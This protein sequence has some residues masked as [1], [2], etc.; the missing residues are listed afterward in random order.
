MTHQRMYA[1]PEKA[2]VQTTAPPAR[3]Q[4]MEAIKVQRQATARLSTRTDPAEREA[5]ATARKI[6][7]MQLPRPP[8]RKPSASE[9]PAKGAF[10][11]AKQSSTDRFAESIAVLRKEIA[12]PVIARRENEGE[13]VP[14][15]VAGRMAA[16]SGGGSPLPE[17]VRQFM[18]P[19]FGANFDGVR[20][21][22]DDRAARLSEQIQA[23]AFTRGNEIFFGANRFQPDTAGGRELIAHELTHTIQQGAATQDKNT[24][25]RSEDVSV[26]QRV[27]GRNQRLGLDTVLNFFADAANAIPGY[28]MFTIVIGM[29]P[30]NGSAVD[31]SAANIL[32]AIVEF[33]PGGNAITRALDAYSVFEK[34]G[35]W[36]EG[37]LQS[38]GISGQSIKDALK[39]FLDSLSW[40]D[41]FDPGDVWDR[42]KSILGDP[43]RRIL[44]FVK[45]LFAKIFDMIR[46]AVL[47]PL[48]E[49]ASQS[50]G[51]DLL[52]AVLGSNPITGDP[53]PRNADTLLGG[54]MKMIGQT[55]IWE[56]IKK[57]NAV[58]RAF[59][60]FQGAM[61]GLLGFV[62][63]I[64]GLIISTLKSLEVTDFIVLP[65]LFIKVGKAFAGFGGKFFDWALGTILDLLEIIFSVVAPSVIVYVKKAAGAFKT[66]LK[67]PIG[68]VKNLIAAGKLGLS[69]FVSRFLQHLKAAL[70]GWLTGALS[71]AGVY[72]PQAIS[73]LEIGKFVISVLGISWP[74]IRAKIVKVLPGGE[75][76]MKV[77]ETAFDIVKAL[78]TGGPTAAWEVIK[79]KLTDLK[80][81]V[82]QTIIG[83]VKD[84][85]VTAAVTKLLSMLSPVGAFIQ[86]IIGIY[87][88]VMFFVERMRQIAQ[89]AA[90]V[91]DS[92]AAIANGQIS[93]A[94]NKVEST[95]AGLLT[96][97]ISFLARIAGLGKVSDAVVKFIKNVQ[98]KVDS[99]IE[100]AVNW[101]V[102]K[103]KGLFKALLGKKGK[104][105]GPVGVSVPFAG[106]SKSYT[107]AVR[108]SGPTASLVV[109]AQPVGAAISE[110]QGKAAKAG[111]E[112]QSKAQSSAGKAQGLA[113][114]AGAEANQVAA[115]YDKPEGPLGNAADATNEKLKA[116]EQQLAMALGEL[117]SAV[118]S[119]AGLPFSKPVS[120]AG[121]SHTLTIKEQGGQLVVFHASRESEIT[122]KL[123]EVDN[124]LKRWEQYINSLANA[125]VK[126]E[127]DILIKPEIEGKKTGGL[128]S[129]IAGVKAI[130]PA[131]YEKRKQEVDA[132]VQS[133]VGMITSWASA[134]GLAVKDFSDA[135]V[136]A[137]IE[138]QAEEAAEKAWRDAQQH[139]QEKM[140]EFVPKIQALDG[141]ARLKYRGSLAK[142]RKGVSKGFGAFNPSDFDVDFFI[143]SDL[144]LT[145][146]TGNIS[147]GEAWG[148]QHAGVNKMSA[149][150]AAA[151]DK[152]P[153]A[154]K[155]KFSIKIRC[156]SNV[157]DLLARRHER[158]YA[159]EKHVTIQPPPPKP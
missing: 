117:Y 30:I 37:Q 21:H 75:T 32:R 116:D 73:L 145:Q 64:P 106:G 125:A 135:A 56:N 31:S 150:M 49:L 98:A 65:S 10:L 142:G 114:K 143:E 158:E 84:K 110:Q 72:I 138:R 71:G 103:A 39:R 35:A 28:R 126:E 3:V 100:F 105:G 29:N 20:V 113:S 108:T 76:T 87:N 147:R 41:I 133:L 54:F 91:I 47:K 12:S 43:V 62:R 23:H 74:Q 68:F 8:E 45:S 99:A 82:I 58:A 40:T 2:A 46:E 60:W 131:E 95:M 69:Q 102:D 6:V 5:E 101:I 89:V 61:E 55:E 121:A 52:C 17:G 119:T 22:N 85:V 14:A 120:M 66:I 111:G 128:A 50:D 140:Q 33:L 79:Q 51:W 1:T 124:I 123:A 146:C 11:S 34:A 144:I 70:I 83:Y 109:G 93:G 104:K 156:V 15:P 107:L 112:A 44:T 139:C 130:K 27:D 80:D 137:E 7:R 16:A 24:V 18:E 154:R 88:T 122:G 157:R 86:A 9:P 151:Y 134:A 63:Q 59:A 97:V 81:M 132:L 42:A 26:K 159:G 92:I 148:D 129:A 141:A 149:D 25:H 78:V 77:L 152:I 136:K 90:A 48:A 155:G 118:N 57:G 13:A 19:R 153:G 96:L 36:V 53:V 38:L 4:R 115:G 67:D 94:A 127:F